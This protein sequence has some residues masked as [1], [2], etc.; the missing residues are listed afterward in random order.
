MKNAELELEFAQVAADEECVP[1]NGF[2]LDLIA[3]GGV[4]VNN[5]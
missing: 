2:E 4:T 1:L 5:I 3:G